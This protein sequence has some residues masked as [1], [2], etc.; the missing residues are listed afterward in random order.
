MLHVVLDWQKIWG[1]LSLIQ[2]CFFEISIKFSIFLYPLLLSSCISHTFTMS[3]WSSGLT[4]CFL[5]QGAVVC[6]APGDANHTLELGLPVNVVS[7]QWWPRRDWSLVSPKAPC[8]QWTLYSAS[9]RR[10]EKPAVITLPSPVPFHSL[11]VLLLLATQWPVRAPV[12]LLGGAICGGPAF[13]HQYT[14][15][16]VQWVNRLLPI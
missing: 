13:S 15:S 9:C 10:C 5:S 7:L 6:C 16:L 2:V 4:V 12:K 14:V 3:H 1:I 8:Q 11:Q